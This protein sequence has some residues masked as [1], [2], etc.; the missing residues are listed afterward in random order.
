MAVLGFCLRSEMGRAEI[1]GVMGADDFYRVSHQQI[2]RGLAAMTARGLQVDVVT[3]FDFVAQDK[4]D[5]PAEYLVE[6]WDAAPVLMP[7]D[8]LE[9]VLK[10]SVRRH[11]ATG[12]HELARRLSKEWMTEIEVEEEIE[13]FQLEMK[14]RRRTGLLGTGQAVDQEFA[15][16][17]A[18][19]QGKALGLSY[20]FE[21]LDSHTGGMHRK[22][23][24]VVAARPSVGKSMFAMHAALRVAE[25]GGGV[26]LCSMEQSAAEFMERVL[27]FKTK[28]SSLKFRTA[29]F[30]NLEKD[31]IVDAG[32]RM[33]SMNLEFDEA[34]S[35]TVARIVSQARLKKIKGRLDLVVIDYLG[36]IE[37]EDKRMH[38]S[39]QIGEITRRLKIAATELDVP[40]MLVSQLNRDADERA[41]KLSDLRESGNIEQDADAVLLLHRPQEPGP[42]DA[43]QNLELHIGKQ[44]HGPVAR[45]K[46]IH[47]RQWYGLEEPADTTPLF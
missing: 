4:I 9:I 44:R 6:L 23:L 12:L 22:E 41:P 29:S 24:I 35:Q 20:G 2:W 13:K 11:Y 38:R 42:H 27:S 19:Q 36:L 1:M 40:V 17:D 43:T 45:I 30:S 18:R 5:F 28:I 26:L 21:Q 33:R 34:P 15:A 14:V 31:A 46:L 47:H 39:Q 16:L 32:D 7:K 37:P 3:L 10:A 8:H 25:V